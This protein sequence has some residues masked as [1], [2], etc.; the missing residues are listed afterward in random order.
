[1]TSIVLDS[2][3]FLCPNSTSPIIKCPFFQDLDQII[4]NLASVFHY[5]IRQ[6][7]DNDHFRGIVW[8]LFE[9]IILCILKYLFISK[10]IWYTCKDATRVLICCCTNFLPFPNLNNKYERAFERPTSLN[11]RQ[12]VQNLLKHVDF[13]RILVHLLLENSFSN[14]EARYWRCL[15]L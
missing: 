2:F 14:Q 11:C 10:T 1:M 6:W 9:G 7:A 3:L 4:I 5:F 8:W 12:V 15:P 13:I